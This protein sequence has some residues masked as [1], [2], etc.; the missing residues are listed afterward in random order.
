MDKHGAYYTDHL[1]KTSTCGQNTHFEYFP[2]CERA[3]VGSQKKHNVTSLLP[4]PTCPLNNEQSLTSTKIEWVSP[5]TDKPCVKVT[6]MLAS[7]AS[8]VTMCDYIRP[9]GGD[10]PCPLL[11]IFVY[12][13]HP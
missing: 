12:I 11:D 13:C 3:E 6:A 8:K 10:M 1:I 7:D 2:I 5:S 4:A 9:D